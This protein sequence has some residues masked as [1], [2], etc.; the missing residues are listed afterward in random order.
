MIRTSAPSIVYTIETMRRGP[1]EAET[2]SFFTFAEA[3][4]SMASELDGHEGGYAQLGNEMGV[5]M[6]GGIQS[7]LNIAPGPKWQHS[8]GSCEFGFARREG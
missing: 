6:I 7:H 3:E 2:R 4:S 5:R 1:P 8:A